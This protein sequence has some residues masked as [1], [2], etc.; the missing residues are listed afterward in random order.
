MALQEIY[1]KL[2]VGFPN[3]PKVRA[4]ARYGPVDAGLA[5]DLYVQMCLFCKDNLTDGFVPAEQVGL[6]VYP[7]DAEHGN[8]L[9]KQLACVGLTK[10]A[11][12]DEA[13]GWQVL[14]YL[15]RNL[16]KEQVGELSKVRAEA[17]RTG[18]HKSR[19]P[20]GR[21][22]SKA[23]SKQVADT[24]LGNLPPRDRDRDRDT[25][26]SNEASDSAVTGGRHAV[27]DELAAAFWERHKTATA[28]P[29][30]AIRGIIRTA[31]A[32]GLPRDDVARALD[33]LARTHTAISGGSVTNA[34]RDM[35]GG[36]N[37]RHSMRGGAAEDLS[38]E[39]YGEGKTRI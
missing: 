17:G 23:T 11:S 31:V 13:L 10:E 26:A 27:A 25:D 2:V 19:K 34:I 12:K 35:R 33:H 5:R 8:Q 6:L 4:L 29:F 39:V 16:S 1:I 38:G 22:P 14:A 24:L 3:D 30:I 37:G 32:N 9:A 7:L 21:K 18:G 36:S 28:Q 15:K 20:A